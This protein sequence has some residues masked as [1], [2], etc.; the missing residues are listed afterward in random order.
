MEGDVRVRLRENL[1]EGVTDLGNI[2]FFGDN[3]R[4]TEKNI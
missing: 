4:V 1:P 3:G 2:S